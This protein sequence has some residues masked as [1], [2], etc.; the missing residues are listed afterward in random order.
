MTGQV[1]K[2]V[3]GRVLAVVCTTFLAAGLSQGGI[4]PALQDLARQTGASTVAAGGLLTASFTAGLIAQIATGLALGRLGHRRVLILGML[5]YLLGVSGLILAPSLPLLLGAAACMG[6]GGGAVLLVGNLIAAEASE[7]AGPL[8][9]VNALFGLGAILSPALVGAAILTLG[10]GVPALWSAPLAMSLALLGLVLT[11]SG[12]IVRAKP[13]PEGA[14]EE[15]Q[16][17]GGLSAIL[18]APLLWGVTLFIVLEVSIEVSLA[19]WLPTLLQRRLDMAPADSALAMSAFWFLLTAARFVAA[20]ASS[21]VTPLSVLALAVAVAVL[22]SA[23][24]LAGAILGSAFVLL[25]SIVLVGPALG[26][27]LPTGLAILRLG[28]PR[29]ASIATGIAFGFCNLGG[30]AMPLALGAVIEGFGAV[31][32]TAMLLGLGLA[33]AAVLVGILRLLGRKTP[34]KP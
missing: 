18:R 25:G 31:A 3:T 20:W 10:R 33:M 4:G 8:N 14:T 21:R 23:V 11:T 12:P 1:P 22:G 7:G 6:L 26:P 9:L 13:R 29:D 34:A 19:A 15:P 28:F 32:A 24:M 5:V 16:S 2:A 17:P 30:A 27:I